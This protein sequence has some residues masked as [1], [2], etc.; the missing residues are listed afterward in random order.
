MVAEQAVGA[1][2]VYRRQAR[3]FTQLELLLLH[4]FVNQAAMAISHAGRLAGI[5][6]D[7]ARKEEELRRLRHA[8]LLISSRT[9]LDE[10]LEAILQMALEVTGAR[11]GILRL[12]DKGG[13][14]LIAAAIVG[15]RLGRPAIEALPLNATSIMGYVGVTRQ[16][17]C[18]P[19]V[20]VPPWSRIYYPLDRALE[21]RAELAVPLIGASGRLIG[22]LNLESPAVGAFSEADS[23]LLQSLATQAVIAIQEVRLL[24]AL[25]ETAER[26]LTQPAQQVL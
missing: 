23:H 11:Y 1:L 16:P 9:R 15:E 6:A 18:I 4:N 25:Q 8:G 10:T 2:Y 21:M 19:D 20:R 24:D 17:L 5:Q 14:N 26:L 3:P 7:L 13:Q 22:V 12:A